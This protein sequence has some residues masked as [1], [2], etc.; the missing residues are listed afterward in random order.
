[1]DSVG[2][3]LLHYTNLGLYAALV[4]MCETWGSV[5]LKLT[6]FLSTLEDTPLL[7][8]LVVA[9]DDKSVIRR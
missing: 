6:D 7:R 8:E 5:K 3:S 1:M 2:G 9:E 4:V